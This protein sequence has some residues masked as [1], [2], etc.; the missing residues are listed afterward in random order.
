MVYVIFSASFEE[1]FLQISI[2]KL[3]LSNANMNEAAIQDWVIP[4]IQKCDDV[5]FLD[6]RGNEKDLSERG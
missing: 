3:D 5:D 1:M 4:L 2:D 6:L